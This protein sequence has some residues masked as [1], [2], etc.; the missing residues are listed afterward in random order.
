MVSTGYIAERLRRLRKEKG[1]DVDAVGAGV[2]RSGKTVS[3]WEAGRNVPSAE[4][5]ISLCLFFG[6]GIDYFYPPEVTRA[7]DGS[8]Y[9]RELLGICRSLSEYGRQQLMVYARGCAQSYPKNK[10]DSLGA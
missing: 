3:A 8:E 2:G 1:L 4:M 5:L 6:V 7:A 10:V 9:E